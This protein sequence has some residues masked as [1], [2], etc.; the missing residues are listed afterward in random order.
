MTFRPIGAELGSLL[1]EWLE[2]PQAL[3]PGQRMN[4]R[5]SDPQ[6]RVDL[7]AFLKRQ[8]ERQ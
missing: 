2:N 5:V 1:A 8:S 7:I 4:F 6:D 3:L